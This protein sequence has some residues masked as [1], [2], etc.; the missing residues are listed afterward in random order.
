MNKE[1]EK[2]FVVAQQHIVE[3]VV[4]FLVKNNIQSK[5]PYLEILGHISKLK[6]GDSTPIKNKI[7]PLKDFQYYL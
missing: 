1:K 6:Y 5:Q 7:I 2:E 4:S 3:A